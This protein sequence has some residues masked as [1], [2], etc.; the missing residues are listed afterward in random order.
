VYSLL[1]SP[2]Q[3]CSHFLARHWPAHSSA[4]LNSATIAV[5]VL[6][7]CRHALLAAGRVHSV[8]ATDEITDRSAAFESQGLGKAVLTMC[9]R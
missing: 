4:A 9:H 2:L 3:V 1:S 6:L 5:P 7:V 8:L